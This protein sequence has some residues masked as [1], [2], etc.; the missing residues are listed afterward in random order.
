MT[1]DEA[2]AQLVGA[3]GA[4]LLVFANYRWG[5]RKYHGKDDDD[6]DTQPEEE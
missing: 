1:L 6:D 2:V 3:T 4:A 5:G